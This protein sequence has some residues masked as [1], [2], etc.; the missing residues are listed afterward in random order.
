MTRQPRLL[1]I[2][3]DLYFDPTWV[4]VR[5]KYALLSRA[6]GGCVLSTVFRK[7]LTRV[8]CGSFEFRGLYLP[9]RLETRSVVRSLAYTLFVVAT[10]L[11]RSLRKGPFD[12]VVAHDPFKTGLLALL[13]SRLTGAKLVVD[14]QGNHAR[15]AALGTARVG[16][17]GRLKHRL[18][19]RLSPFVLNRAHAIKLLYDGQLAAF[20]GLLRPGRR[21]RFHEFVPVRLFGPAQAAS[22]YVLFVGGPWFM[23]GVD[24][25][26][27]AFRAI[28]DDF[29]DHALKLYGYTPDR[30]HFE[31]LAGGHPRI[32][33][34]GPVPY[35]AVI[36][37]MAGCA[38]FVL[39]SRT[40]AM[41]R[42]LLEAMASR[43]PII[44][45][46]VDGVPTY[47]RDGYNGLLVEPGD[48]DDLA[49]K[50]RRVL[51]D[52]T[53]AARLAGN[54][55]RYVRVRL[56]EERYLARFGDLIGAVLER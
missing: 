50:M 30:P 13:V 32:E 36:R 5:E 12:A 8:E 1:F 19:M 23:K 6:F 44:A 39:P 15:A 38:L 40:E 56:S 43:K 34:H 54:G 52:Q 20:D 53:L 17:S 42:V 48:P 47:V 3:P 49:A 35:E 16:L 28:A 45:S 7:G 46:R 26:I 9:P 33:L 24:V 37:L 29:P 25:L 41:G 55:Y 10:A 4:H 2:M 27:R 11:S 14:V 18:V 21:V 51:S 22:K 31:R